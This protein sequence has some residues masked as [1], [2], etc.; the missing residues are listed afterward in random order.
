MVEAACRS[1]TVRGVLSNGRL[2]EPPFEER[3]PCRI[4]IRTIRLVPVVRRDVLDT[5]GYAEQPID[6]PRAIDVTPALE[7]VGVAALIFR[8][9]A[10]NQE[11]S[12]R[13]RERHQLVV[14][15]FETGALLIGI[16]QAQN[17]ML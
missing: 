4:D 7:I 6:L 11:K 14:I 5:L 17:R 16:Q 1:V 8:L 2:L 3:A 12:A 10:P 15:V 9:A 13:S